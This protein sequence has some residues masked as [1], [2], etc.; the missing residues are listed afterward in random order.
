MKRGRD[1]QPGPPSDG[2]EELQK[3][4]LG[5]FLGEGS[6]AT[7]RLV[8][9]KATQMKYAMKLIEMD[10]TDAAQVEHER[11]I[12]SLLGLHRHIV[13]LVDHFELPADGT[14]AFVMELADGGEVFERICEKGAYSEVEAASVVRQVALA[15]AFIHTLG[16]VHRDLKPENLL[17]TASGDVKVADFGL[18]AR[19]GGSQPPLTEVC[20]TV[21]YL[22]PEVCA[23]LHARA[24][25]QSFARRSLS[26]TPA[27]A[28]TRNARGMCARV[29]VC[30]FSFS[31]SLCR[32]WPRMLLA[33]SRTARRSTSSPS[34]AS[35]T[36][37]SALT[38]PSTR[39]PI[40]PTTR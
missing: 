14:S 4:E 23:P 21:T 38:S 7:V 33:A 35:C 25:C 28:F 36:R 37:C 39:A 27:L 26:F 13:S 30:F 2:K 20:G 34:A 31:L 32:C 22:A 18:A 9:H 8:T 17:L 40:A 12:L 10:K 3:Y 29:C 5:D 16:V 24:R 15:L 11:S 1:E 19:F 6:F